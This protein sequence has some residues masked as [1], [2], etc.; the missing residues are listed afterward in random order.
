MRFKTL[1]ISF[2]FALAAVPFGCGSAQP[3]GGELSQLDYGDSYQRL[4]DPEAYAL[5]TQGELLDG[6]GDRE[7]ALAYFAQAYEIDEADPYLRVRLAQSYLELGKVNRARRLL[8]KAVNK[9]PTDEYAWLALARLHGAR[10]DNAEKE[11]AATRAMRVEPMHIQSALWLAE[12]YQ[13][14]GDHRKAREILRRAVDTEGAKVYAEAHLALGEVSLILGDLEAAKNQLTRFVELRPHRADVIADLATAYLKAG[15][16][17]RSAELM[18]LALAKDP[19]DVELRYRLIDLY[20]EMGQHKKATHQ[21]RSL[22][23]I[24]PGEVDA[25]VRRSCLFVRADRPYEGRDFLVSH[26]GKAPEDER[27]KI[28]LAEIEGLLGR[29]ETAELLLGEEGDFS[30][31][32]ADQRKKLLERL[33]AW[34]K[35]WLPC[36]DERGF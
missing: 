27:A 10:G 25:I 1:P 30:L 8:E 35:R 7:G 23:T 29:L 24:D 2:C 26:L 34:P 20:F 19:S 22:P 28:V 6:Q 4:G 5:Y 13:R 21:L 15:E 12:E 31:E 36:S 11:A 32:L 16:K 17:T 14:T 33:A 18:A 9:D 3:F